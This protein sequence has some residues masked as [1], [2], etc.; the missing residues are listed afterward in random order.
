MLDGWE[1]AADL[2][3]P[4]DVDQEM[5]K[6]TLRIVGQALFSI[7]L[8]EQ[9]VEFTRAVLDVLED[10]VHRSQNLFALPAAVPT[11]ATAASREPST[12]WMKSS[13]A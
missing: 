5:M 4:I 1:Q 13:R 2:A 11:L 6:L 8:Q 10:I 9:A 7:D 3:A 12:F